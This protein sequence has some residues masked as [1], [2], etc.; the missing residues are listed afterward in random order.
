MRK[1][2]FI[3]CKGLEFSQL[4]INRTYPNGRYRACRGTMV[5]IEGFGAMDDSLAAFD[6]QCLLGAYRYAKSTADTP[7][8]VDNRGHFAAR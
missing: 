3:G 8:G 7:V 6:D 5:A 2:M 4:G 1:P